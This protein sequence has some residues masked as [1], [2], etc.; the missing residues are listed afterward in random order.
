M[1]VINKTKSPQRYIL[2]KL[3]EKIVDK[4]IILRVSVREIRFKNNL[5]KRI[6]KDMDPKFRL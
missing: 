4:M 2:I 5:L 6:K 1:L 3:K